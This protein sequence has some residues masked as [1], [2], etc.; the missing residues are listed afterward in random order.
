MKESVD[1]T[2]IPKLR[3]FAKKRILVIGELI[4]DEYLRG[5]VSRISP[6][7]P[8]PVVHCQSELRILGGAG[9]VVRNL[10]ALG[11]DVVILSL[12]GQDAA[13]ANIQELLKATGIHKKN[14]HLLASSAR[15][16]I[17]KVRI[18]AQNQQVCR[19][20]FED[21]FS[22]TEQEKSF[23]LDKMESCLAD[24]DAVIFSDYD[25]GLLTPEI[26]KATI[27]R[28][29]AFQSFIAV[30]PQVR[31]FSHYQGADLMTPNLQEISK[32]LHVKLDNQAKILQY[33][34]YVRDKMKIGNLLVT[35]GAEGMTFMG[36]KENGVVVAE[37]FP[38]Q[39]ADVFDVTGAGDTVITLMTLG[40]L[41]GWAIQD[42]IR[43]ANIG[44]GLVVGH[45]GATALTV[46]ELQ[47]ALELDANAREHSD[48]E[49]SK[50]SGTA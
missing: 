46:P 19:V 33:G 47:E 26:I 27:T 34:Q 9:N 37:H 4:L 24:V 43:M 40:L 7:A 22:S 44:A 41:C 6:E 12:T 50:K 21:I 1:A 31:N 48:R 35:Q 32:S 3:E 10:R 49:H 11:V 25:K 13:A 17:R 8:V 42:V 23:L 14:I 29:K 5:D 28:A 20:D 36:L 45:I 39:A 16:T 38:T 30:D 15:Q 18:M 2:K